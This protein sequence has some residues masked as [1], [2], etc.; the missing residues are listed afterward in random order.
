MT[1]AFSIIITVKKK[2]IYQTG[3]NKSPPSGSLGMNFCYGI[4]FPLQLSMLYLHNCIIQHLTEKKE[5][6]QVKFLASYPH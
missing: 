3:L 6:A 2:N 5:K 4:C 1:E